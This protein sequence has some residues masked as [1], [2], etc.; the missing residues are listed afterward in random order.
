M[1]QQLPSVLVHQRLGSSGAPALGD[2]RGDNILDSGGKACAVCPTPKIESICTS[3]G[4]TT[5]LIRCVCVYVYVVR[6]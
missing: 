3:S 5:G 4:C 2:E 6:A 1:A